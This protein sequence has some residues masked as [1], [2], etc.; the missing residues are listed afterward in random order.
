MNDQMNG[1][2]SALDWYF[3]QTF[4]SRSLRMTTLTFNN[5]HK[6]N[7]EYLRYL[8]NN[9]V[10]ICVFGAVCVHGLRIRFE[11]ISFAGPYF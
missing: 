10:T 8:T 7:H 2:M 5:G 11:P 1:P 3:Q 9:V 4:V 6:T